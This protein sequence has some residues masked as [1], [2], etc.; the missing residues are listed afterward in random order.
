M[1]HD[2]HIYCDLSLKL[3]VDR[4]SAVARSWLY[5]ICTFCKQETRPP[6]RHHLIQIAFAQELHDPFDFI[7][8]SASECWISFI[9]L[10]E[11]V[12]QLTSLCDFRPRRPSQPY[13][14][15]RFTKPWCGKQNRICCC[16]RLSS[17]TTVTVK[18]VD[19][20]SPNQWWVPAYSDQSRNR[21]INIF[22]YE[23]EHDDSID[24]DPWLIK[25]GLRSL[26]LQPVRHRGTFERWL[27]GSI[28]WLWTST[29]LSHQNK[30]VAQQHIPQGIGWCAEHRIEYIKRAGFVRSQVHGQLT[31]FS[32]LAVARPLVLRKCELTVIVASQAHRLLPKGAW[33]IYTANRIKG[34]II[35]DVDVKLKIVVL[36]CTFVEQQIGWNVRDFA[37]AYS[38]AYM[39][40]IIMIVREQ[41]SWLK[42]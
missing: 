32:H 4:S 40:C 37:I 7:I 41:L 1:Q 21:M 24:T 31:G 23:H 14:K 2:F 20:F 22:V 39:V 30:D 5:S 17:V 15:P 19:S 6:S 12:A 38:A 18:D 33:H 36:S 16:E 11:K 26:G 34:W 13:S 25:R 3:R 35:L 27:D 8:Q 9:S 29:N 42:K 10:C 28:S